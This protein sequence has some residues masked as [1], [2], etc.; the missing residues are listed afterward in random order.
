M[1]TV[2]MNLKIK[3]KFTGFLTLLALATCLSTSPLNAQDFKKFAVGPGI[4]INL[5]VFSPDDVNEYISD[6]LSSYTILFGN[7]DMIIYYELSAFLNFK[8]RWVD[9]Q[10]TLTYAI[11]P[12]IIIGAE[13]FYFSRVSPGVLANFFIPTGL[14]GKNALFI[15]GGFQY[16]M[17]DFDNFE[18][19]DLGFRLQLGFDLQ[20][21]GFNLQPVLALNIAEAKGTAPSASPLNMNYTGGQIG[22]NMSFHK[23]VSHRRF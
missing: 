3:T 8:T 15:G 17:M 19:N 7:T 21:G 20:F 14:S 2:L 5:G 22:I 18:G 10:P 1:K 23:P 16:H 11:A 12:K 9:V 4:S 6:A 13:S